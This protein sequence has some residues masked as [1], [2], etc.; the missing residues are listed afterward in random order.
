MI[1]E[2]MLDI[3]MEKQNVD[4]LYVI[5]THLSFILFFL[6]LLKFGLVDLHL[7]KKRFMEAILNVEALIYHL[8]DL[9]GIMTSNNHYNNDELTLVNLK[10]FYNYYRLINMRK[11]F[12]MMQENN[13]RT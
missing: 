1:L 6:S 2:H 5:Y 10:L 3:F 11:K 7:E 4:G 9:K 12:L 13:K 8:N